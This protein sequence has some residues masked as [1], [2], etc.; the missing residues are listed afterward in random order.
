MHVR[1]EEMIYKD[2]KERVQIP[3]DNRLPIILPVVASFHSVILAY[4]II[5]ITENKQARNNFFFIDVYFYPP[6]I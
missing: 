5:L 1:E 2:K 3:T 4:E 6:I